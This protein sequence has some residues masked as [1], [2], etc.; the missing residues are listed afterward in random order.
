MEIHAKSQKKPC[1]PTKHK[2]LTER[3]GIKGEVVQMITAA[4]EVMNHKLSSVA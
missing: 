3:M 4:L 1:D 2:I